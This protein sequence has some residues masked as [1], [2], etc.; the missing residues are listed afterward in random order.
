VFG[1]LGNEMSNKFKN[2][3]KQRVLANP[4]DKVG[5]ETD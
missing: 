1:K 4:I 3:N 2:I 5:V